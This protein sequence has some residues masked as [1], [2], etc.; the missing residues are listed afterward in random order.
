MKCFKYPPTLRQYVFL[1]KL[2]LHFVNLFQTCIFKGLCNKN[3][4]LG[5]GGEEKN[6]HAEFQIIY[7]G[8][9]SPKKSFNPPSLGCA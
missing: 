9:P 3:G 7:I 6:L 4:N 1:N 8:I 5:G 2:L